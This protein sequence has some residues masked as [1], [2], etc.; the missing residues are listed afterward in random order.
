MKGE[1]A[2]VEG[3]KLGQRLASIVPM[4]VLVARV[5]IKRSYGATQCHSDKFTETSM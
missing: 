1:Q 3:K 5:A 2:K 4:Y